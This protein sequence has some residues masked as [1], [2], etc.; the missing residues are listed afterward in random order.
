[1]SRVGWS[2]L[3]IFE[4]PLVG[5]LSMTELEVLLYLLYSL[6]DSLSDSFVFFL[7]SGLYLDYSLPFDFIIFPNSPTVPLQNGCSK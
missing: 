6:K 1:M 4:V 7:V 3:P 5:L 2:I